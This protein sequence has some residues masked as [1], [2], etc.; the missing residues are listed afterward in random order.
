[1]VLVE[2]KL[3]EAVKLKLGLEILKQRFLEQG[4]G[5]LVSVVGY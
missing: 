1:L 4:L 2:V 5:C 3:I